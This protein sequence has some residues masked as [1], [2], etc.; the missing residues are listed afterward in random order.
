MS[1]TS[2]HSEP[3]DRTE[4]ELQIQ[5]LEEERDRLQEELIVSG[6][7]LLIGSGLFLH[8]QWFIPT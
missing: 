3:R 8:R 4:L 2:V 5:Q 6:L 7:F 1:R